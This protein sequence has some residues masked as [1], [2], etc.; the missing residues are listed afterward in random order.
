MINIHM[1]AKRS[2]LLDIIFGW[3]IQQIYVVAIVLLLSYRS[4]FLL[5]FLFT[6]F[7]HLYQFLNC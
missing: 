3:A 1:E 7:S 6:I 2:R 4:Y 5:A